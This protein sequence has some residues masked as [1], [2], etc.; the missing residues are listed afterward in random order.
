MG[1][2]PLR[3]YRDPIPPIPPEIIREAARIYISV[4]ETVTGINFALER[5]EMPVLD[6]IR[7]NLQKYL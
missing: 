5:P 6:R 1:G 2:G 3:P 7:A 4:F